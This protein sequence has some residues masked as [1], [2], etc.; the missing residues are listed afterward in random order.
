MR[1]DFRKTARAKKGKRGDR[2]PHFATRG[3]G[4]LTSAMP[5]VAFPLGE[6]VRFR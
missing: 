1:C 5:L 6:F 2:D 3:G 4:M